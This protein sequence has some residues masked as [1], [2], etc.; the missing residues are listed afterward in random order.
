[1]NHET[2]TKARM[3]APPW[4]PGS[5]AEAHQKEQAKIEA[6]RKATENEPAAAT[7]SLE[8][9]V[10]GH[11]AVFTEGFSISF[12]TSAWPHVLRELE[13][14]FGLTAPSEP[15]PKQNQAEESTAHATPAKATPKKYAAKD[16]NRLI[17]QIRSD[18]PP[19]LPESIR[20]KHYRDPALP[21]LYI[22][23]HNTGVASWVVQYKR[24]GRQ[25][26]TKL[27][28]VL[29]LD[30]VDA[31]K[32][33]KDLLARI[34][35]ELIDPSKTKRERMR[36]NKV[37]FATVVPLFLE[38]KIRQ[39]ELKPGT[40]ENWKIYL[41]SGFHFQPLHGLP[42]D[43][44]TREQIQAR[45][46]HIVIESGKGAAFNCYTAMRVFFKW[47]LKTGKLPEG[48]RNPMDNVQAPARNPPRKRVLDDDE[49]R[50]IWKTCETWEA[51]AVREHQFKATTGKQLHN[52]GLKESDT[53]RAIKLLFLTGCRAQEIGGLRWNDEVDLDHAE[54][55]IPGSRRKSRKSQ[56]HAM[57]LHVPL[58]S[59]AVEILRGVERRPNNDLVFGHSR[60]TSGPN[61]TNIPKRIDIYKGGGVPLPKWTIHDIRRTFRTRL[62]ALR[63]SMDVAEAL[64]GHVGHRSQMVRVYDQYEYWPEKRQAIAMWETRLREIIDGT[65]KKI[66]RGNF[67]QRR[68]GNTA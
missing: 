39:G 8:V 64:V 36:A 48:H 24:L 56:E 30:R 44:I 13:R 28:D 27:G 43:E 66:E 58:A 11:A 3:G 65:A 4:P 20:E 23:L 14:E 46:D 57:D 2:E 37:T 5:Y 35:L 60:R 52:G 6:E 53:P 59:L 33:A 10:A 21:N 7:V 54:L 45:I 16:I 40:A 68:E 55:F 61:L 50:L 19:K 38:H 67:G 47:A 15:K 34:T 49:I 51:D 26:K 63:V 9:P 1:M 17:E 41:V 29:V 32:A 31:I 25:K 42:I 18:Q 22:R 62:A 12:P